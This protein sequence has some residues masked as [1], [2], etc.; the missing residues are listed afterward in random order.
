LAKAAGTTGSGDAKQV[1][2]SLGELL[3]AATF[4]FSTSIAGLFSSIVLSLIFKIYLINIEKGFDDFCTLLES[5]VLYLAPP[6][7]TYRAW[8]TGNEQLNN[9][10]QI[11]DVQ[12]FQRFG[13]AVAPALKAAVENAIAPL[14]GKL[15]MTVDKIDQANRSGIEGMVDR[16]TESIQGTAGKELRELALVLGEM[17]EALQTVQGR[18]S[19]S[20]DDFANRMLDVANSFGKLISESGAQLAAAKAQRGPPLRRA[21]TGQYRSRLVP[22]W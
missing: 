2:T 9:L 16:F 8:L 22:R 10:K 5:R 3:N 13:Q 15:D 1:T 19:G 20:G 7:L 4:K 17:K 14:A 12:F 6:Y 21:N 18:L 11:N